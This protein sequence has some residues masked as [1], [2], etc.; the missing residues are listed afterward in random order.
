MKPLIKKIL[1]ESEWFNEL[2]LD[3][4]DLPFEIA[5]NPRNR[6]PKSNIFVMKTGWEYGYEHPY[7]YQKFVF[8][9]DDPKELETFVNVC[10]FYLVLLDSRGYDRWQDVDKMA[11]SV[12]LSIS[13]YDED[14]NYGTPKDMSDF[15]FGSDYPAYLDSVVISY[16]DK[17]GVEYDVRLKEPN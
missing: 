12:G 1:K 8:K 5:Q 13:S 4:S 16:F 7:N 15:I 3:N 10:K 11:K 17:G 14:D 9:V 6:P 2:E